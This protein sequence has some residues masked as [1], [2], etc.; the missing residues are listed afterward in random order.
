[1]MVTWFVSARGGKPALPSVGRRLVGV[2][3]VDSSTLGASLF[4]EVGRQNSCKQIEQ[5]E[6]GKT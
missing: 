5:T 2:G 6:V 4:T 3:G 1:M